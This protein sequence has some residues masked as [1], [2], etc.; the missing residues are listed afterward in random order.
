M[1]KSQ[2]QRLM[3]DLGKNL[4]EFDYCQDIYISTMKNGSK[5]YRE[6][7]YFEIDGYTFIWT[8]NSSELLSKK[9]V[10]DYIII[11]KT[12]NTILTLKKV[13]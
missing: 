6:C 4:S 10:G 13:I 1:T 5:A 7:A 2:A 9:E 12:A 3:Q 11:P 8:K